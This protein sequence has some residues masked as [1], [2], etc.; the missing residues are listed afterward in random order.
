MGAPRK[1][2]DNKKLMDVAEQFNMSQ[3]EVLELA[4]L[5]ISAIATEVGKK[6][7]E[8]K[9]GQAAKDFLATLEEKDILVSSE[10][11]YTLTEK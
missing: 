3:K 4:R 9:K 7:P 10:K 11:R 5:P 6:A 8:G 2:V 1:C